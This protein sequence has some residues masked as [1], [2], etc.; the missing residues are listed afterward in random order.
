MPYQVMLLTM[1]M[2]RQMVLKVRCI[3][4]NEVVSVL[5]VACFSCLMLQREAALLEANIKRSKKQ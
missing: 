2:R 3:R 1:V 4:F 5:A